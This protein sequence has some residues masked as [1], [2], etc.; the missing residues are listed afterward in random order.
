MELWGQV[1]LNEHQSLLDRVSSQQN[2]DDPG[3]YARKCNKQISLPLRVPSADVQTGDWPPHPPYQHQ[4]VA[5]V[6][7]PC[8][9]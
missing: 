2:G 8:Y 9:A 3:K 4:R 1:Q 5:G 6:Y 7:T